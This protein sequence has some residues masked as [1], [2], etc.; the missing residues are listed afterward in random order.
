MKR[1][2][3]SAASLGL[4]L[5]CLCPTAMAEPADLQRLSWLAGCWAQGAG[6]P[7]SVEH[8]LPP[9]GGLMLGLSRIVRQGRT[10]EYEFLSIHL[11]AEGRAVYTARPSGQPAASFTAT[12]L[13]EGAVSFENPAHDFPQRISYRAEGADA[14][15]ARIEGR[16]KG[17]ERQR[18]FPMRRVSCDQAL[19]PRP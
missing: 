17:V 18:D 11:D 2:K 19:A 10:I 16:L 3:R 9:A 12:T 4:T 15:L 7:G 14:L 5:A 13:D 8:W 1:I 6:E